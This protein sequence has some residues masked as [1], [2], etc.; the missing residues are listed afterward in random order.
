MRVE[1]IPIETESIELAAFLK[2]AQVAST[3]GQAKV[4]VHAGRVKVNG[5]VERRRGRVLLPGDRVEVG[6]RVLEVVRA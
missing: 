3:G 1:R 5:Q 4:L 2:W 6:V